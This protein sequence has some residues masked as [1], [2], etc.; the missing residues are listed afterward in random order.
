MWESV[1][2]VDYAIFTALGKETDLF[3]LALMN[4]RSRQGWF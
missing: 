3:D 2:D 1:P 4:S